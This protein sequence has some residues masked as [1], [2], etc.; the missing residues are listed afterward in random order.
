LAPKGGTNM[1]PIT[2]KSNII[3]ALGKARFEVKEGDAS[4]LRPENGTHLLA[5]RVQIAAWP[6]IAVAK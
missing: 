3:D 6:R 2:Y 5:A 1:V 4:A